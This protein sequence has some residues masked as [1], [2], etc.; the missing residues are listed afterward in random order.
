MIGGDKHLEQI[1]VVGEFTRSRDS[2]QKINRG[3]VGTRCQTGKFCGTM[4]N[5]LTLS[6]FARIPNAYSYYVAQTEFI[7]TCIIHITAITIRK[8]F[9]IFLS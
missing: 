8:T 9:V 1:N 3:L 5:V 4:K 6:K 7:I 2:K